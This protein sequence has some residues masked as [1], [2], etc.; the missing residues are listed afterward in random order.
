MINGSSNERSGWSR[1]N[2]F[3]ARLPSHNRISA[4]NPA[5]SALEARLDIGIAE[6]DF[7]ACPEADTALPAERRGIRLLSVDQW[8]GES[9]VPN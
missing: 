8:D 6:R 7:R 1:P 5:M 9:D 4:K 2:R 3:A